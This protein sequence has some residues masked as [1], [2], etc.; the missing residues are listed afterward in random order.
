MT[1]MTFTRVTVRNSIIIKC[2]HSPQSNSAT[3][4]LVDS[5]VPSLRCHLWAGGFWFLTN[6]KY[7]SE[8]HLK[9]KKKKPQ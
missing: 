4:Q 5:Q 6:S 9:K 1:I 3:W 8:I 7:I 2:S